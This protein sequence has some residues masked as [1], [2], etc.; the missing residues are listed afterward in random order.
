[1]AERSNALVLKTRVRASGPR[2]RIP[3]PPLTLPIDPSCRRAAGYGIDAGAHSGFAGPLSTTVARPGWLAVTDHD[4]QRST[5]DWNVAV[6]APCALVTGRR[7][8][9][10]S[11]VTRTRVLGLKPVPRTVA[12]S[13]PISASLAAR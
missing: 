5:T 1:V 7:T 12:G 8:C 4:V 11:N 10:P 2:V 6:N 9:V 13:L 3:P